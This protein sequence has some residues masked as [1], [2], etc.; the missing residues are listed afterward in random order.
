MRCPL[1]IW[2]GCREY[3][4]KTSVR[5]RHDDRPID[6]TEEGQIVGGVTEPD[7]DQVA[8]FA[9]ESVQDDGE[10]QAFAGLAGEV[11][12]PAAPGDR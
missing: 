4:I 6:E 12:K 7:G 3:R 11:V 5:P 9:G 2:K 10:R 8:A 1:A